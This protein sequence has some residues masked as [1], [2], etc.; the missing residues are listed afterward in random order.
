MDI[1][2]NLRVSFEK[3]NNQDVLIIFDNN[4]T[5]WF[6]GK[7][8]TDI[9]NYVHSDDAIRDHVKTHNIKKL[10]DITSDKPF[11][12]A[13]PTS[14]YINT[15]GVYSLIIKKRKLKN[16]HKFQDWFSD[17]LLPILNNKGVFYHT[18]N[19]M[20]KIEKLNNTLKK[21]KKRTKS[22]ERNQIKP[23]YKKGGYIYVKRTE[24]PDVFNI[25]MSLSNLNSRIDSYNNGNS[26]DVEIIYA[27][28]VDYPEKIE[29]FLKYKLFH[30]K[31]RLKKE[32]YKCSLKIIKN[33]II[34][35][36]GY[37]PDEF[38]NNNQNGGLFL[39]SDDY[40]SYDHSDVNHASCY[41]V[42]VD[43]NYFKYLKYKKKY[44]SLQLKHLL[45]YNIKNNL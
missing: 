28:H 40:I 4:G 43:S 12:N 26:D 20:K 32:N 42:D 44:I 10:N 13:Q 39:H 3:Y 38:N 37:T 33:A 22:L 24:L 31:Y 41:V 36:L 5:P 7:H 27:I 16:A 35:S 2:D 14:I 30:Y 15:N 6:L 8:I 25:G 23:K 29:L 34:D 21:Y 11:K 45:S 1:Y 17:N 19:N 18:Y 9:L